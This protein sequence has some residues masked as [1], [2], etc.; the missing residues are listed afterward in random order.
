MFNTIRHLLPNGRAWRATIDKILRRFLVGLGEGLQAFRVNFDDIADDLYPP[1]TRLLDEYEE[2]FGLYPS[3]LSA[4]QRRDRIDAAW[5]ARGGQSPRYIQDTLRA[6]G[7]DVYVHDWWF[8]AGSGVSTELGSSELGPSEL[9]SG[10]GGYEARNPFD[11]LSDSVTASGFN[12]VS[13][14]EIA[15]TNNPAA[16]TGATGA[17]TGYLLVNLPTNTDYLIP[18]DST[19]W[20]FIIYIGGQVW[21]SSATIAS[22]RRDEFEALCLKICPLQLWIGLIVEYS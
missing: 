5:K 16:I 14:G 17:P 3:A 4:E 9:W 20:P 11:V 19:K 2:Q 12:V 13:N 8:S 15:I 7:F 6:S 1:T 18:A 21:G 22:G 10:E